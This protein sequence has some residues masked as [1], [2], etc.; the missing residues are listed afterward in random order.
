MVGTWIKL[1]IL[2]AVWILLCALSFRYVPS[3][4][5]A[6]LASMGCT[7][8]ILAVFIEAI[9]K[10]GGFLKRW[11]IEG[12]TLVVVDMQV[13]FLQEVTDS[14]RTIKGV[15]KEIAYAMENEHNILLVVYA[16][17]GPIDERISQALQGYRKRHR[18][19][20]RNVSTTLRHFF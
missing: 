20:K 5:S 4:G 12:T 17:Y 8:L 13:S 16:G 15:L 19:H 10:A 6:W 18:I 1:I 3:P 2:F 9:F 7:A 14:E 11:R